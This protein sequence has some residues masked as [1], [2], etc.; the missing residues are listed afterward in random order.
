MAA[1]DQLGVSLDQASDQIQLCLERV[2]VLRLR[3]NVERTVFR[4][5][6]EVPTGAVAF[7]ELHSQVRDVLV[8][9]VVRVDVAAKPD[10][11]QVSLF[12]DDRRAVVSGLEVQAEACS[13]CSAAELVVVVFALEQK[14]GRGVHACT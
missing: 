1:V 10:D 4:H 3:H 12:V 9:C 14:E 2:R 8:V 5:R 6:L 7:V 13:A 11:D